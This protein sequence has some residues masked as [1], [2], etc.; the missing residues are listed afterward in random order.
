MNCGRI[1]LT[2]LES[3]HVVFRGFRSHDG[4]GFWFRGQADSTWDLL[5]RAGRK[6]YYLPDN[7]DLGRF[8]AWRDLAVAYCSLPTNE[9]EQLALAQHHGLATR[10][11]DWTM[12]PLV[13]CFFACSECPEQD[14]AIHILEA[15]EQLVLP[16]L[17]LNGTSA[18]RGVFGYIPRA[19]SPRVLNQKA[20]FTLHCDASQ[21]IQVT[22]STLG[23]DHPNLVVL[24]I[25]A[26]MKK[27]IIKL[28][29]DYGVDRA[30]L[31]PDLDGLSAHI[32]TR[33]LSMKKHA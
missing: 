26:A 23:R 20:L 8:K 28:L 17:D 30:V 24:T 25:P 22:G 15:P 5:P 14:G 27:E 10:L 12:N 32:N 18:A 1:S 33:T 2:N 4:F 13:A 31:F 9:P 11:L 7:R 29:G 6:G 3:L 16:E 19:I 21:R